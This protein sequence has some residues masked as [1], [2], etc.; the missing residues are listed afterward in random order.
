[1]IIIIIV[2]MN[3]WWWWLLIA[4]MSSSSSH[5]STVTLKGPGGDKY[6]GTV[7]SGSNT[8][9]FTYTYPDGRGTNV[10]IGEYSNGMFNGK[11]LLKWY[12]G[13]SYECEWRNSKHHGLCVLTYPNGDRGLRECNNGS[14]VKTISYGV[15]LCS[16]HAESSS[17]SSSI[18]HHHQVW[19]LW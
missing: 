1:M 8:G 2:M 14:L 15:W 18:H 5:S 11:G 4:D 10:Y 7:T 13:L 9:T 16:C 3:W 6:I 12:D 19:W 17:S